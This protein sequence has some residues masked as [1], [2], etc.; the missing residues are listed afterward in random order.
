MKRSQF[1][2]KKS[3]PVQEKERFEKEQMRGRA[4]FVSLSK[5]KDPVDWE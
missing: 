1:G 3:Q 4:K 5:S 2:V